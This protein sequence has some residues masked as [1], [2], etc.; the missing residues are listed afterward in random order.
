M[1]KKKQLNAQLIYKNQ[2]SLNRIHLIAKIKTITY[3]K[4]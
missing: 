2:Q 1:K 4:I 3:N